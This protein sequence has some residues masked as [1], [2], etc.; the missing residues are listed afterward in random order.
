MS[1]DKIS[2]EAVTLSPYDYCIEV[3]AV[4]IPVFE[5]D[6]SGVIHFP[7]RFL[8]QRGQQHKAESHNDLIFA[9]LMSRWHCTYLEAYFAVQIGYESLKATRKAIREQVT[10]N[11]LLNQLLIENEAY[12][13]E[14]YYKD[15]PEA[16]NVEFIELEALSMA[17]EMAWDF[18]FNA[19]IIDD[20]R[21][22]RQAEKEIVVFGKVLS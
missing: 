20:Y 11:R 4:K 12:L 19:G 1:N 21:T 17:R 14:E 22:M 13:A 16:S 6:E 18:V 8:S 3:T 15:K 10:Y 7:E 9:D 2:K 5:M